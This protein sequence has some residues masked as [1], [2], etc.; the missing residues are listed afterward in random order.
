MLLKGHRLKALGSMS[1]S[2]T[3]NFTPNEM[4]VKPYSRFP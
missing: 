1:I 3:K 2:Y 4:G